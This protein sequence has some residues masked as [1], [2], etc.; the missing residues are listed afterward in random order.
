MWKGNSVKCVLLILIKGM[1]NAEK[2]A[3]ETGDGL[4]FSSL[5][6]YGRRRDLT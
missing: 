4:F 1:A 2:A 3:L 6:F 5:L